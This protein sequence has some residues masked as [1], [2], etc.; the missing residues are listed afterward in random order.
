MHQPCGRPC[1]YVLLFLVQY[2]WSPRFCSSTWVWHRDPPGWDRARSPVVLHVDSTSAFLRAPH[3]LLLT[4]LAPSSDAL[5]GFVSEST[6][7]FWDSSVGP[8]SGAAF[9]LCLLTRTFLK[10]SIEIA[11]L[12][13]PLSFPVLLLTFV[14][15]ILTIKGFT[16]I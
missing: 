4:H 11:S 12:Q 2:S 16:N 13:W 9:P 7:T 3:P 6:H 14:M 5:W 8:W 10:I 15:Y 1:T